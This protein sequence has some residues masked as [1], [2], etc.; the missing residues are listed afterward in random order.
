MVMDFTTIAQAYKKAC[1]DVAAMI[2][3]SSYKIT[4]IM[5]EIGL[6]RAAFYARLNAENWEP[7][8]LE[9][10]GSI[11]ASDPAM[12]KGGAV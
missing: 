5:E 4:H 8:H 9:K 2:K 11:F 7:Q 3:R 10:F 6:G 1:A 12:M